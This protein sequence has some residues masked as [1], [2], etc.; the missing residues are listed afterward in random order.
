MLLHS[1]QEAAL[2]PDNMVQAETASASIATSDSL[3]PPGWESLSS[4][5]SFFSFPG[6]DGLFV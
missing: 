2:S 3:Q 1:E 5:P 4:K 6:W